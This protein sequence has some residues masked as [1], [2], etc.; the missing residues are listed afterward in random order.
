M[1]L[2]KV[3]SLPLWFQIHRLSTQIF[4]QRRKWN[5]RRKFQNTECLQGFTIANESKTTNSSRVL[6]WISLSLWYTNEVY[7]CS[8]YRLVESFLYQIII[9]SSAQNQISNHRALFQQ[10]PSKCNSQP[11]PSPPL[12]S[13]FPSHPHSPETLPSTIPMVPDRVGTYLL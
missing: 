9:T 2:N 3:W 13:L 8:R 12:P 7:N 6:R 11:M 10:K 5:A 4:I 1:R